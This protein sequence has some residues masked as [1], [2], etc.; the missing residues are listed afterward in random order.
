MKTIVLV[1]NREN[2]ENFIN[3]LYQS[4]SI[5]QNVCFVNGQAVRIYYQSDAS[6]V[7]KQQSGAIVIVT[8]NDNRA[9]QNVEKY[10][11]LMPSDYTFIYSQH[12][13]ITPLVC[14]QQVIRSPH[15]K[16]DEPTIAQKLRMTIFG[17]S[18]QVTS[19]KS[20]RPLRI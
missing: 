17:K 12:N 7:A 15:V 4:V 19:D 8:G 20:R 14:I 1:G 16:K 9:P 5:K 3:E 10:H 11:H 2:A 13:H 18:S 6:K